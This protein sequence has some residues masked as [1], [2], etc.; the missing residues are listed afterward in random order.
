MDAVGWLAGL[1][2]SVLP[3]CPL[4]PCSSLPCSALLS[5]RVSQSSC[6]SAASG[7]QGE[8]GRFDPSLMVHPSH[9]CYR[10]CFFLFCLHPGW[11][12]PVVA[13][14]FHPVPW[15]LNVFFL[16]ISFPQRTQKTHATNSIFYSFFALPHFLSNRPSC[17]CCQAY[18]AQ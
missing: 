15:S 11:T 6:K 13:V 12:E 8:S 3:A 18:R 5:L 4:L 14:R 1:G 7:R 2:Q 16:F 10:F 17:Y 9:S